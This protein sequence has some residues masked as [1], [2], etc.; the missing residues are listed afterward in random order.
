MAAIN[1]EMRITLLQL[2]QCTNE[3]YRHLRLN[4]VDVVDEFDNETA[5]RLRREVYNSIKDNKLA[6]FVTVG[7]SRWRQFV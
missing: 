6:P 7:R 3:M 2:E 4:G 1:N 5:K